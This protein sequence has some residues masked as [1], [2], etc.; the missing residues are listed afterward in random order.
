METDTEAFN[1]LFRQVS[2]AGRWGNDDELGTL[3][4]LTPTRRLASAR[5]VTSGR[6]VSVS[7]PFDF[8]PGPHNQRPV[9]RY[10]SQLA[11][12]AETEPR[13]NMDFIGL[14]YHGFSVT[15]IDALC[16]ITYQGKMYN[17]VDTGATVSTNGARFGAVMALG[18]GVVGRGVLL[19]VPAAEGRPWL[20]PGTAIDANLLERVAA[21]QHV[22]VQE[23]DLLLIRTGEA[24]RL[25]QLGPWDISQASAG[26]HL[27]TAAWLHQRGVAL[28]GSDGHTDVRPSPL[29]DVEAPMH[30]LL[31]ASMGMPLIDN[32]QLGALA[33]AC[34]EE[35]R[36]YF[37]LLVA[38]L[39][40]PGATGSP[41]N[42]IAFF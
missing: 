7:R 23:G 14:E 25:T 15:H 38:P 8:H 3:N 34:E 6:V 28:V 18:P 16:H 35:G 12:A 39:Q 40:V 36:W 17:E 4:F 24:E 10:M 42:P 9:L 32:M 1:D 2:N 41:A 33:Q 31:V 22:E 37:L 5:S 11:T 27:S 19:D 20:E 30:A 13:S 26:L 21:R 29:A